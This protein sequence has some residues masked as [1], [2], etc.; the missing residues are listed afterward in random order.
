MALGARL[1]GLFRSDPAGGGPVGGV[2]AAL[3]VVSV[4]ALKTGAALCI[5]GTFLRFRRHFY[6]IS[7]T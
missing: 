2:R 5:F 1:A 3:R 6:M 4:C 7:K